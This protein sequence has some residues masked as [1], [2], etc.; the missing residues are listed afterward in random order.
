[1]RRQGTLVERQLK[2]RSQHT[3]TDSSG[4]VNFVGVFESNTTRGVCKIIR[5]SRY[6]NLVGN[7]GSH[8]QESFD[9]IYVFEINGFEAARVIKEVLYDHYSD[10]HLYGSLFRLSE[11]DISEIKSGSVCEFSTNIQSHIL[12]QYATSGRKY[13]R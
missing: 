12:R 8:G 2:M 4:V 10:H 3:I 11:A 13:G 5:A 1:M 6:Y 7:A 9:L